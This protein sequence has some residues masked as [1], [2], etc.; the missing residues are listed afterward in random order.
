[1]HIKRRTSSTPSLWLDRA[2]PVADEPL[3]A[4]DQLDDI[5]APA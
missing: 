3:P 1:M 4:D 5:V 2:K